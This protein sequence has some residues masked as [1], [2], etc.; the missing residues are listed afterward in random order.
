MYIASINYGITAYNLQDIHNNC[1]RKYSYH[2]MLDLH[3]FNDIS[4]YT[5]QGEIFPTFM[6]ADGLYI[7]HALNLVKFE[8]ISKIQCLFPTKETPLH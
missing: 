4:I 1:C 5:Y 2:S 6:L 3:V 8:E 7:T